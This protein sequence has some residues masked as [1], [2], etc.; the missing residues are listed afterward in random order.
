[1]ADSLTLPLLKPSYC[2]VDDLLQ[3]LLLRF[4]RYL[5][6]GNR[7]TCTRRNY[8]AAVRLWACYC[9]ELL[10]PDQ[11]SIYKWLR[12]RR[13]AVGV[14]MLNMELS[15]LRLFYRWCHEWEYAVTDYSGLFPASRRAPQR[16]P[17]VL[18][19]WQVG[20]LLAAPDLATFIGYRDHVMLRMAYETGLRASELVKLE[21][22]DL[23][24]TDR[25]IFIRNGKGRVDRYA[26]CSLELCSLLQA[27]LSIRRTAGP[28]KR[29]VV[30][31]T[32]HGKAFSRGRAVWE[33]FNRY[34]RHALG[35]G[36]GYERIVRTHQQK[37]WSGQY[38]HLLRASFATHLLQNGCDLR[39]VQKMLGHRNLNT[40]ARYLYIDIEYLK[41]AQAKLPR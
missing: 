23:L 25:L 20:Q 3:P 30:F 40:T 26:P 9:P 35:L 2:Q 6:A 22:G 18:D 10:T 33:I 21:I 15:A 7:S 37:P 11:T 16:L 29:R 1:M 8:A 31:I 4:D 39:A 34:S 12:A 27:W 19:A 38:P 41:K 14:S 28:G 13:T 24:L 32:R 17:R 5:A 36:R